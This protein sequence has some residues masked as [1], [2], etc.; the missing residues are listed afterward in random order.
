MEHSSMIFGINK[1][2]IAAL[3]LFFSYIFIAVEKIPKVTIAMMGASL[4]LILGILPP[5][6]A[7]AYV[8]FGVITLLVSMMMIVHISSKSGI[9]NWCA[10]ELL[11]ITKGNP[12][13]VLISLSVL[14][15][16]LSTFLNNVTTV[17]LLIP[18]TFVIARE[19]KID[20]IPF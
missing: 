17:I 20:P 11:K 12:I 4:T 16:I 3:I 15:G 19:L 1:V 9:F 14:T 10:I 7:F 18:I 6:K 2:I 5:D 13:Y 8:D